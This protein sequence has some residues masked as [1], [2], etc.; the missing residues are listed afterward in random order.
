M[1]ASQ[2]GSTGEEETIWDL[3]DYD[4]LQI[5]LGQGD[6]KTYTIILKDE[7]SDVKRDDGREKAG[8]NWEVDISVEKDGGIVWRTWSDFK[9]FYRG[10]EK[11]DAGKLN[12]SQ[13]RRIGLMMRRSDLFTQA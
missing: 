2:E 11:N 7:K 1:V 3:S 4:G 12:R 6:G 9:P 8:I 13:I 5:N 10:K